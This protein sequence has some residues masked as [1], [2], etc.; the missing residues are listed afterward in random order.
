M[1]IYSWVVALQLGGI[2]VQETIIECVCL[3]P[4]IIMMLMIICKLL[5]HKCNF[6]H[7][8]SKPKS[9]EI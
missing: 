3:F 9:A 2:L 5:F 8:N 6:C 7:K 4:I 1:D